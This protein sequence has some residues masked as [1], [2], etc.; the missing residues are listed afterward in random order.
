MKCH[1]N[2]LL[3]EPPELSV[4][5]P[6]PRSFPEDY[7]KYLS[8]VC[9][10]FPN[11]PTDAFEEWIFS[12]WHDHISVI[13]GNLDF[14]NL[15]FVLESWVISKCLKIQWRSSFTFVQSV[16]NNWTIEDFYKTHSFEKNR[17]SY[18]KD[19]GTWYKPIWVLDS[20]SFS[21][22]Q[23]H[24][25]IKKPFMLIEGHTR[26]GALRLHNKH[27]FAGQTHK[28]WVISNKQI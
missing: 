12:F 17:V 28:V 1:P 25:D 14:R 13:Y 9:S 19:L 22:E 24:S 26:L 18:W 10:E 21:P 23:L 6:L 4:F 16:E 7:K 5:N 2:N 3:I 27:G 8:V 15:N 11:I 20:E